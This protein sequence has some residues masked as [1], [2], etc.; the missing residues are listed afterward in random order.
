MKLYGSYQNRILE[1]RE[2]CNEI[3]VG[4]G[5]TEFSYSDRKA[6]EVIE[7]TDQKHVRVRLLDHVHIG[8][9]CMDNNWK[10]V[11]NPNNPV[12]AMVKRG[13]H[14]YSETTVSADILDSADLQTQIF[15]AYNNIDQEKLRKKGTIK[16]YHRVNVTFGMA[17]YYFDYDF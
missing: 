11:S 13:K 8:D 4:T 12:R 6:Y 5:M 16:K 14:W 10:L 7:V 1:D 2:F 9:G 15:L 17:D 3:T